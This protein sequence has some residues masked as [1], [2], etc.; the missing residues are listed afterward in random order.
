MSQ[1]LLVSGLVEHDEVGELARDV[2]DEQRRE[3][4]QMRR[5]LADWFG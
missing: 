4:V 3:I 2:R 1:H 5:W